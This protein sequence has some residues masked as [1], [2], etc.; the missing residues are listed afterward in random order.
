MN[1]WESLA[2]IVLVSVVAA[3]LYTVWKGRT[4]PISTPT[5]ADVK[6]SEPGAIEPLP[7]DLDVAEGSTGPTGPWDDRYLVLIVL[8]LCGPLGLILLWRTDE[9]DSN[10]KMKITI[11]YIAILLLLAALTISNR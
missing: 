5:P 3:K 1:A 8:M 9:W 2:A 4:G 6:A 7:A 10:T 11:V